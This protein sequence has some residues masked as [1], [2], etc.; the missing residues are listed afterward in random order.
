MATSAFPLVLFLAL[1][2]VGC[3]HAAVVKRKDDYK[4]Y[5]TILLDSMTFP[6]IVPNDRNHVLTMVLNKGGVGQLSTDGVRDAYLATAEALAPHVSHDS[7]LF[8]QVIVNGA[9]NRRLATRIGCPEDFAYPKFFLFKP[10]SNESVAF[11]IED[12][13]TTSIMDIQRW[14]YKET[15]KYL[16]EPGT[17]HELDQIVEKFRLATDASAREGV[18]AEMRTAVATKLASPDATVSSEAVQQYVKTMEKVLSD[19]SFASQ[20]L[21]RLEAIV[22]SDKVSSSRKK[23]FAERA[24]VI[25]RFM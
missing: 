13:A 21:A 9:Q 14:I 10:Q 3:V 16:G 4:T 19:P 17:I 22:A 2:L 18:M 8:T 20:E 12:S 24:N 15:G 11:S 5:G 7:I 25:K 6:K 23:E 1:F